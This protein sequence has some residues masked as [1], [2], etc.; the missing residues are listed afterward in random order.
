MSVPSSLRSPATA[1]RSSYGRVID[2]GG[3]AVHV[4]QFAAPSDLAFDYFTD[5]PAVFRLLP[6]ML[7]VFP[8]ADDAFRLIVGASDGHRHSMSAIFDMQLE[9][10]RDN[11]IRLAPAHD[12]PETNLRGL[13]FHGDLWAEAL[14][15][16]QDRGTIV[17][18][19]VEIAMSIPIPSVL[20]L[21]PQSFLQALGEHAMTFKMSQMISGFAR[22]IEHDFARWAG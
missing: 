19:T 9:G 15:N 20:R 21:M 6:D 3:R 1:A 17:E 8:Y 13:T 16:P 11:Y 4:F 12:G 2:L 14:F 7:D 10:E 22:S 18:Y 5:I